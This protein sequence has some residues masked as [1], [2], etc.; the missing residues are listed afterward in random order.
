LAAG[1]R[2]EG[3]GAKGPGTEG[4]RAKVA[5]EGDGWGVFQNANRSLC[6]GTKGR[7]C[8]AKRAERSEKSGQRAIFADYFARFI[9]VRSV[10]FS[11]KR[12]LYV[13]DAF[14]GRGK[15]R[16]D[17]RPVARRELDVELRHF[18]MASKRSRF[19]SGWL[20]D[21]R[22][23]LGIPV[24]ELTKKLKVNQS[25][26]FRLEEKERRRNISLWA[27]E[28]MATA[29]ECDV[30]YAVLPKHGTV[31][32]LAERLAWERKIRSRE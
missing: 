15:M 9:R 16:K 32:E 30:V 10:Q 7:K 8:G 13:L 31:I 21:L 5:V 1:T 23:A 4:R 25:V 17:E 20:R 14:S 18:R 24:A 11:K 3:A 22:R 27:L 29:M 6:R 12:H 26:L 19:R 28:R 2:G